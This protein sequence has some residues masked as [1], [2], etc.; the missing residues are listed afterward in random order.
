MYYGYGYRSGGSAGDTLAVIGIVL[1]VVATVAIC[2]LVMPKSKREQLTGFLAKLHDIVNFKSL[3]IEK[4][5]KVLYVFFS[6]AAILVGFFEIFAGVPF[7]LCLAIIVLGPI[8]I[9]LIYEGLMLFIICVQNVIEI[10][11]KLDGGL[12]QRPEQ[13]AL[14]AE[15]KMV[16]CTQCGTRY[17]AAA[18]PCPNCGATND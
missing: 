1:A 12:A 17:D 9:R 14:P 8:V 7:L 6:C 5:L 10:N 18:G 15:P 4:I 11:K 2:I 16:F 3:I 13:P